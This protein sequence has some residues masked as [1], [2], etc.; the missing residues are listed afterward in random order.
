MLYRQGDVMIR[1]IK[2]LPKGER[3]LIA[4]G[5]LAY[6]EV[7]GHC[8]KIADLGEGELF[9]IQATSEIPAGIFLSVGEHGVRIVHDEHSPLVLPSGEYE[10]I[11]Q[12]EYSPA[13]IRNVQ[14]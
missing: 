9:E 6:G 12:K 1:Q 2:C 10:V 5:I 14:D 8:H 11:I 3:K 4:T 13:E 7:T